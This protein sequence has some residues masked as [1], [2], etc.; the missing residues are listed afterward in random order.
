MAAFKTLAAICRCGNG[1][2]GGSR[3]GVRP[4]GDGW[5]TELP[6]IVFSCPVSSRP[7]AE[8]S[9][10]NIWCKDGETRQIER[11]GID[12]IAIW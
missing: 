12:V 6:L 7:S 11:D 5:L 9:D 10:P 4:V 1:A 3:S 8:A 2:G